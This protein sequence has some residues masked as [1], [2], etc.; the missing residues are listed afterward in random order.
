MIS[1]IRAARRLIVP[2]VLVGFVSVPPAR[3]DVV[4]SDGN[5]AI[6][7]WVASVP[8][9]TDGAS[10]STTRATIDGNPDA[11]RR[12][13]H[14]MPSPSSIWTVHLYQTAYDPTV[15]GAIATLDYEED[16]IEIAPPFPGAAIGAWPALQQG[17]VVY[18]GPYY[19][20]T[21]T[22]WTA[23]SLPG[24]TAASFSAAGTNNHPNFTATGSPI[25][26][27]YARG[28]SNGAGGST[29]NTRSGIDNWSVTLHDGV[30]GVGGARGVTRILSLSGSNPF[31]DLTTLRF[32]QPRE[33]RA[34]VTI[35]DLS[36]R[37]VRTLLDAIHPAGSRELA[38]N[39]T[40]DHGRAVPAGLYLVRAD[41]AGE[42][43]SLRLVRM[44]R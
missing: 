31:R 12:T 40:N 15:S 32:S 6:V 25:L 33:G 34:Q 14:T 44:T 19:A 42:V 35:H 38:W 10:Q 17:G 37:R 3:A 7:D 9:A 8:V 4:L 26:F 18:Y 36:G 22:S 43:A 23:F 2:A 29:Y 1:S 20:F 5:F 11:Y 28:N 24:L 13:V 30:T 39:G 41:A 21:E 27:G 16:H